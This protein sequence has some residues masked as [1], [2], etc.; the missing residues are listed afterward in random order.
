MTI[1]AEK[2]GY[3]IGVDTH[4]RTHS[5]V[6]VD[7]GTGRVCDSTVFPVTGPGMRR[8]LEWAT[9][10]SGGAQFLAAIEG[11]NSYG[12]SLTRLWQAAGVTVTEAKPPRRTSRRQAGKSDQIDAIAAARSV[13]ATEI[14]RLIQPRRDGILAALRVLLTA[15]RS[16]DSRRTADR[17]ALTALLRSI[18]LGIDAR[19]AL[20]DQQLRQ[21]AAWRARPRDDA[22]MTTIRAEAHRLAVAVLTATSTLRENKD[23]LDGHVR[24]LAPELPTLAGVGPVSAAIIL[25]AYSFPGRIHSEAAFAR[26]AGVAPIP[27]SSGNTKRHRLSRGGD[28]QLNR[29][30]DTIVRS[31]LKHD[32]ETKDYFQKRTLE[33]RTRNEIQRSLKRY[34]ARQ[35]FR[36]L[37]ALPA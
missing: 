28:R 37:D 1:V 4:A 13:L 9:R 3:V 25:T 30:M 8:A 2:F 19:A 31:R 15:R 27:A 21:I 32:Q 24:T 16:L 14:E 6:V 34:V 10:R 22:A 7:S 33:G 20:T 12:A 29:A 5:Y 35:I 23:A 17:N 26:L 18:D 11:T 36:Y